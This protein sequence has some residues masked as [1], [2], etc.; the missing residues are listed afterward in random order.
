MITVEFISTLAAVIAALVM[1][2]NLYFEW[3]RARRLKRLT[4]QREH[5]FIFGVLSHEGVPGSPGLND[6]LTHVEQAITKH[7]SVLVDQGKL[8]KDHSDILKQIYAKLGNIDLKTE[9]LLPN[10]GSSM[11]DKINRLDKEKE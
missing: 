10:G 6:R 8:L 4:T 1:A 2:I 5:D 3:K 11:A 9:Q 7:G